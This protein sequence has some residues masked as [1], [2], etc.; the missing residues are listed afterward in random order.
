MEMKEAFERIV[1]ALGPEAK[2]R[3]IAY[4]RKIH[5]YESEINKSRK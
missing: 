3:R 4:V 1:Q 5:G 2:P